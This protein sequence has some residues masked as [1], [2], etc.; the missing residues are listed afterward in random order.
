MTKRS[1][2]GG[3]IPLPTYHW[4][5][6]LLGDQLS[7]NKKYYYLKLKDSFFNEDAAVV[8]ESMENGHIYS[9]IRF[10]LYL[11]SLKYD[12]RLMMTD[13]I[14]YDLKNID[15]L[16]R[17]I[18]CDVDHLRRAIKIFKELDIIE[19][20]S[21]GEM[22]MLDIQ[23]YI[24][25]SSTEADRKRQYRLDID[26][27][28]GQISDKC[29]DK[30]PPEL[31]LETELETE[32]EIEK[33]LDLDQSFNLFWN[34]YDKKVDLCKCKSKWKKLTKEDKDN[35]LAYVP[36]YV[37]ATPDKQYRKNPVTFLNNRSWENEI[38]KNNIYSTKSKQ[39]KIMEELHG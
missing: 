9:N 22:Y 8:L 30:N 25:H 3:A 15:S 5:Y 23:N 11:K 4:E 29:P 24:G 37:A 27:K 1:C 18:R 7:D 32:I 2:G 20:L 34:T 12:G 14:P 19:V 16:A 10:K 13:R 21:N 28:M 17:V 6:D 33:E 38:I 39:E 36:K 35:L 31:E 26:K